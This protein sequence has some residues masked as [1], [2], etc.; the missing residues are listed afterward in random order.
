M[1]AIS[2]AVLLLAGC[3]EDDGESSAEAAPPS[4]IEE[5]AGDVDRFE[6]YLES[7]PGIESASVDE[8]EL[9]TDFYGWEASA[10]LAADADSTVVGATLTAAAA[11]DDSAGYEPGDITL[12]RDGTEHALSWHAGTSEPTADELAAMFTLGEDRLGDQAWTLDEY[13]QF[14]LVDL[15][16]LAAITS[17]T[18]RIAGDDQ[19]AEHQIWL[20]STDFD[21]TGNEDSHALQTVTG[22][23]PAVAEAWATVA[24]GVES[25]ESLEL[26]NLHLVPLVGPGNYTS[27]PPPEGSIGL[28]VNVDSSAGTRA[29]LE[30]GPTGNELRRLVDATLPALVGYPH[31][32]EFSV[33]T[34]V[35]E[36]DDAEEIDLVDVVSDE[37]DR[38][39]GG[40]T[41]AAYARDLLDRLD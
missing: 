34:W 22:L 4:S 21:L 32:S 29:E 40:D 38:T 27:D 41:V 5:V 14:R 3:G 12:T 15:P 2:A 30:T 18:A 6:S 16:D 1:A 36:D 33:S 24:D 23:G 37:K 8:V 25:L 31:G 35:G 39:V 17:L 11:F 10:V 7:Q 28:S 9:D 19:L 20:L 26:D 13:G